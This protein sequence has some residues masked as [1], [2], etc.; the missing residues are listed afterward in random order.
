MRKI[1]VCYLIKDHQVLLI[2]V[3]YPD[4]KEIWN[5]VS[6]WVEDGETPE[7]G[8]IREIKEEIGVNVKEEDLRLAF[9][10]KSWEAPA[11]I[12]TTLK[13]QGKPKSGE[14]SIREVRWFN[15]EEVPFN[16]MIEDNEDW[17]PRILGL[18]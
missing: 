4:G 13:W 12:F 10:P 17:L 1:A 15:F 8:I 16:E 9:Q 7:Q 6:G 2:R 11:A 3:H 14:K 18:T 5:G